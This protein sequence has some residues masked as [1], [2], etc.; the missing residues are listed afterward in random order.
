[1]CRHYCL[2]LINRNND[3]KTEIVPNIKDWNSRNDNRAPD[4]TISFSVNCPITSWRS[5][6]TRCNCS[7]IFQK[8]NTAG[9]KRK[10]QN[11]FSTQWNLIWLQWTRSPCQLFVIW[12][13]CQTFSVERQNALSLVQDQ[14]WFQ[15]N[16]INTWCKAD[17]K[18][19]TGKGVFFVNLKG[20]LEPWSCFILTWTS[21][22]W[23]I[24]LRW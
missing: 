24:L 12:K 19:L 14:R 10:F 6:W 22:W 2:T 1:M 9:I 23:L 21:T 13:K 18:I 17:K 20:W 8:L 15:D 5:F 11:A 4:D 16:V 3:P 7:W